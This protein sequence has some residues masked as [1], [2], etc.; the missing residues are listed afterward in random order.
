MSTR[1][2]HRATILDVARA[3][4]VSRQTVSN[5]VNSPHKVAPDTLVRVQAEIDR[6]GFRPSRAA[7]TLKQER[8]GAWGLE[9]DARGAGRLGSVLDAFLVELTLTSS[10]ND[11]H[12]LPFAAPDYREPIAAYEE[13]LASRLA[14]GFIL[15]D[16]RHDDPRPQWLRDRG[17]RSRPSAGSGTTPPRPRGSTS[18]A[19]PASRPQSATSSTRATSERPFRLANRLPGR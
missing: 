12:I 11:T 2:S 10:R 18:T 16:T 7:R 4:E 13:V 5:V 3:A 17:I 8:A 19:P 9:I 15:T 1:Q 14:D 6:L